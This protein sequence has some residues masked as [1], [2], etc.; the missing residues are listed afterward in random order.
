[1]T[2]IPFVSP[3]TRTFQPTGSASTPRPNRERLADMPVQAFVPILVERAVRN[4][5]DQD[6]VS[7]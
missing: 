3:A 7:W 2:A 5:L 6:G 1:M 4:R